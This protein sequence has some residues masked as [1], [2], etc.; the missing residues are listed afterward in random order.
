[1]SLTIPL[2]MVAD[3]VLHGR[4]YSVVYILG[5]I[6]VSLSLSLSLSHSQ[7]IWEVIA[8]FEAQLLSIKSNDLLQ[9]Y[10]SRKFI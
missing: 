10:Q 2:A 8:A 7:A 4:H 6:Q 1:M 9:P 5:C 3:V